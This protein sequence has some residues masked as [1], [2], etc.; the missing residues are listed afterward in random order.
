[1]RSVSSVLMATL[2]AVG[3]AAEGIDRPTVDVGGFALKPMANLTYRDH[4]V[5]LH[6]KALVGVGYNSNV[7]AA[8]N[9]EDDAFYRFIAGLEARFYLTPSSDLVADGEIEKL[10]YLDQDDFDLIGGRGRIEHVWQGIRWQ[11][12]LTGSFARTDEPLVQTGEQ[13]AHDDEAA[14]AVLSYASLRTH[15]VFDASIL[16]EDFLDDSRIFDE[17]ERDSNTYG[18]GVRV[19]FF[20]ARDSEW[21]AR[22]RVSST[23]YDDS[24]VYQDSLGIL[25]LI[26]YTGRLD[27]RSTFLAEAGIEFRRYEGTFANDPAFDGRTAVVPAGEFKVIWPWETGSRLEAGLFSELHDSVTSNAMWLY[28]GHVSG[29]YRLRQQLGLFGSLM[30]FKGEDTER[31][32]GT[33]A[34]RR[35][36][37]QTEAGVE[38]FM[39]DGVGVRLRTTY[40]KSDANTDADYERFLAALEFAIVF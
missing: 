25:G 28:G 11:S 7:P 39:R 24:N 9:A 17:D 27:V 40:T 3:A 33:L 31:P 36:T 21:Y 4:T 19:G 35:T 13:I 30:L 37:G 15:L 10:D 29:R 22:T 12:N 6:P 18:S 23:I 14:I 16:R 32:A 1:M 38:Y 26:G 20:S 8:V 2:S 5:E 34:E